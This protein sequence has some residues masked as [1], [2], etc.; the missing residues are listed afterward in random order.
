MAEHRWWTKAEHR[1]TTET[2]YPEPLVGRLA[3]LG[4]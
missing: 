2:V 3:Q 4:N 1:S